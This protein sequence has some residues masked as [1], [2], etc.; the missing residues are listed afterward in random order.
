MKITEAIERCKT[1]IAEEKMLGEQKAILQSD[2]FADTVP[3]VQTV[4][5]DIDAYVAKIPGAIKDTIA[6]IEIEKPKPV[7]PAVS[8]AAVNVNT[9]PFQTLAVVLNILGAMR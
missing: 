8:V 4:I 3:S 6:S 2:K 9:N 1:L 5:K 7:A